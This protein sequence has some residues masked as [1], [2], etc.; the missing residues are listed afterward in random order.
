MGKE[1]VFEASV[2]G[3]AASADYLGLPQKR[4][5]LK[6]HKFCLCSRVTKDC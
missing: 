5:I 6:L 3:V 2:L 1:M 4:I